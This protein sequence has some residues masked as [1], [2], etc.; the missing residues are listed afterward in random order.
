MYIYTAADYI[1]E[2]NLMALE[3]RIIIRELSKTQRMNKAAE[4]L[5][6]TSDGLRN[7][8]KAHSIKTSEWQR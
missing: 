7:K 5:R 3:R 8:M 1:G 2:L 4:L 6:F